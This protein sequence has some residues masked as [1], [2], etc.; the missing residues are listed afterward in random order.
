MNIYL[1]KEKQEHKRRS[2]Y[3]S[4]YETVSVSRIIQ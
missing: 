1:L 2:I 3:I 4:V